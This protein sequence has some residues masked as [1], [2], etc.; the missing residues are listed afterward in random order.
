MEHMKEENIHPH[1][2]T[3]TEEVEKEIEKA[4]DEFYDKER[5]FHFSTGKGGAVEMEIAL[6]KAAM[7]YGKN[8]LSEE[9]IEILEEKRKYLEETMEDGHYQ[10]DGI[11]WKFYK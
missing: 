8:E 6:R 11:E 3:M 1:Y 9:E 7:L 2:Y 5:Q 4:V 10:W